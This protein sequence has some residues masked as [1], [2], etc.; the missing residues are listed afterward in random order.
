M[1]KNKVD[2]FISFS[3]FSLP[4]YNASSTNL[5]QLKTIIVDA[6]HGGTDVGA[7][8]Q[9]ENS[10]RSKEKDVTLAIS[11]KLV[12]ELKK[13]LPDVNIVPTRTTDIYQ[14]PSEKADI[15]NDEQWRSFSLHTCR[16]RS[17]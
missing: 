10:L 9:Y 1:L 4:N 7:V 16:F 17:A 6:G 13:Q 5:K 11:I 3:L 12:A 2:R 15:A 8:G 14:D